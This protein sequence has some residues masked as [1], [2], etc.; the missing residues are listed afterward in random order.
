MHDAATLIFGGRIYTM[1]NR[2]PAADAMIIRG[3]RIAWVGSAS[4]LSAVPTDSYEM[5]DLQGA[6]VLPGFIDSHVHFLHWARGLKQLDL[7]GAKS[8]EEVLA[9]I[10]KYVREHPK[11]RWIVG[12]GWK[13]DEWKAPRWPHRGDLDK[14]CADKPVALFSKDDHSAWCNTRL[15]QMAGI[16]IGTPN[17]PGG[18]IERDEHGEATG[19]LQEQAAWML[20][21]LRPAMRFSEAKRAMLDGIDVMLRQGCVGVGNFDKNEGWE[22]LEALDI[23][24]QLHARVTQY[25]ALEVMDEAIKAG[26]RTGF[27]SS[28]LKVGGVKLF[29]DGALGS[30]TA[31]MLKPYVGS[32]S[33]GV[34]VTSAD[35]LKKYVRVCTRHGLS[36]AIH[37]IGDRANRNALDAIAASHHLSQ[38]FRHRVEH[39]QIVA[40]SDVQRFRDIGVIASMQPTHATA[41]IDL[42]NRYL[43]RRKQHSY[44]FRTFAKLEVPLAF[45]SDAPIE[46]LAP[47]RGIH[48]AVTGKRPRGREVFNKGQ[49]LSVQQAVHGFTLGGAMA[50]GDQ[51][52]R[53]SLT[54]GKLADLVVLDRDIMRVDHDELDKLKV[55]A[56]MVGGEF[57]FREDHFGD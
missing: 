54:V 43:G 33:T 14:I 18:V 2:C 26:L 5:V 38:R 1:D 30:Q 7:E 16:G 49:V 35:D 40:P 56:T 23:A 47:L 20:Y 44:R 22:T 48:D 34:A 27:G 46:P 28:H 11:E 4:E 39:C 42:M 55:L 9:R 8:Y 31:L 51:A 6:T 15:L 25:F 45:G 53:G 36:C 57:R 50:V 3:E 29:A 17:P 21:E 12:K 13:K 10:R 41:D 52:Q 19:I 32:K 37:A 24:G